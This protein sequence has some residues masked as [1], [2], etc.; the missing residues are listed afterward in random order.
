MAILKEIARNMSHSNERAPTTTAFDAQEILVRSSSAASSET[1]RVPSGAIVVARSGTTYSFLNPNTLQKIEVEEAYQNGADLIVRL[2]DGQVITITQFF[3]PSQWGPAQ[4]VAQLE[5]AAIIQSNND[6]RQYLAQPYSLYSSGNEANAGVVPQQPPEPQDNFYNYGL[7]ALG[8][9]ALAL[10]SRGGNRAGQPAS[11]GNAGTGAPG[12]D[13]LA[14]RIDAFEATIADVSDAIDDVQKVLDEEDENPSAHDDALADRIEEIEDA[15]ADVSD[16]ISDVQAA[17]DETG[18]PASGTNNSGNASLIQLINNLT[19]MIDTMAQRTSASPI[20]INNN[21][22]EANTIGGEINPTSGTSTPSD[23]TPPILTDIKI[24]PGKQEVPIGTE[25]DIYLKFSENIKIQGDPNNISLKLSNGQT[26]TLKEQSAQDTL[27]FVTTA[28]ISSASPVTIDQVTVGPSSIEDSSGNLANLDLSGINATSAPFV[29]LRIEKIETTLPV[30]GTINFDDVG[31][32]YDIELFFTAP[33]QVDEQIAAPYL[34]LNTGNSSIAEYVT[35]SGTNTLEFK[36]TVGE[37]ETAD[38]FRVIG[39][40][41]NASIR[42]LGGTLIDG[43]TNE[44]LSINAQVDTDRPKI[45]SYSIN[46]PDVGDTWVVLSGTNEKGSTIEVFDETGK[47]GNAN[48]S[49]SGETWTFSTKLING[50]TKQ[51][52]AKETTSLRVINEIPHNETEYVEYTANIE[53]ITSEDIKWTDDPNGRPFLEI[54]GAVSDLDTLNSSRVELDQAQDYSEFR[55]SFNFILDGFVEKEN[56]ENNEIEPIQLFT[57]NW[58]AEDGAGNPLE[59]DIQPGA[60]R[61]LEGTYSFEYTDEEI[62]IK[63]FDHTN[64]KVVSLVDLNGDLA[65]YLDEATGQM[66]DA[67]VAFGDSPLR[68]II[69]PGIALT[70]PVVTP[71]TELAIRLVEQLGFTPLSKEAFDVYEDLARHFG[72]NDIFKEE[73]IFTNEQSFGSN[74]ISTSQYNYGILLS[75][76]SSLDAVTGSASS[77]IDFL[78]DITTKPDLL[79]NDRIQETLAKAIL[80]TKNS[81]FFDDEFAQNSVINQLEK[82]ASGNALHQ[83]EKKYEIGEASSAQLNKTILQDDLLVDHFEVLVDDEQIYAS[84]DTVYER[85]LLIPNYDQNEG[86]LSDY[87]DFGIHHRTV[88]ILPVYKYEE[89]E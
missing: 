45:Q 13:A 11:N 76:M 66:L 58:K 62:E 18:N 49:T 61:F 89:S 73:L 37:G 43:S 41:D 57:E 7:A 31:K 5:Q 17:L 35:G 48:I 20:T 81:P 52:T 44:L 3:A 15:I 75:S 68:T 16:A 69:G 36:Y 65:N 28:Q 67:S 88:E 40:V 54:S 71:V 38:P 86:E 39:L 70:Q 63:N 55:T 9:A 72:L 14:D 22:G 27:Q 1:I 53:V 59:T 19:Q 8:G 79:I 34:A 29:D 12:D 30:N 25:V 50:S 6:S 83:E 26:A 80:V 56:L 77:T 4:P 2:E 87:Q 51:F 74:N 42:S 32:T 23:T 82:F 21:V 10:A 24:A 85:P 60:G 78:I 46:D 33:V 84:Y 64:L 47:I